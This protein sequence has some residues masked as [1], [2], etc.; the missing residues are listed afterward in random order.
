MHVF[1]RKVSL[2]P[3][4]GLNTKVEGDFLSKTQFVALR[5]G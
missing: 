1:I 3:S 5:L 4:L 2:V